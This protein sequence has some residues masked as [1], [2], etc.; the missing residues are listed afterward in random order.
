MGHQT[1]GRFIKRT[2]GFFWQ[3]GSPLTID[4]AGSIE[5]L[6]GVAKG[7]AAYLV[8]MAKAEALVQF[9]ETRQAF[10]L[11]DRPVWSSHKPTGTL[12]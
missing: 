8:G 9:G 5:N 6:P 12:A 11:V 3:H 2:R 7:Q 4:V 1:P 10:E